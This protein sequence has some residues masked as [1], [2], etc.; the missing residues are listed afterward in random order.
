MKAMLLHKITETVRVYFR[1][2]VLQRSPA[3][4]LLLQFKISVRA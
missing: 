4:R 1:E 3:Y 2:N